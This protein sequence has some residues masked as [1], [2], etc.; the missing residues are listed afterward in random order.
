[1]SIFRI[2]RT[3]ISF[4]IL[5]LSM[6]VANIITCVPLLAQATNQTKEYNPTS[7]STDAHNLVY[8]S[9]GTTVIRQPPGNL[10]YVNV[11]SPSFRNFLPKTPNPKE[12]EG[13]PD[14]PIQGAAFTFS[15]IS[16]VSDHSSS[17]MKYLR[18]IV[19][20]I[21]GTSNVYTNASIY[22]TLCKHYGLI[23]ESLP[24]LT[25]CRKP[26][27]CDQD[28]A[29]KSIDYF[30]PFGEAVYLMCLTPPS[31]AIKPLS[32]HAS[33]SLLPNV[34]VYLSFK[35]DYLPL[36]SYIQADV[37]LRKAILSSIVRQQ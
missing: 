4:L 5:V 8:L 7:C 35:T 36:I 26:F 20:V 23:D 32:C 27:A 12:P 10:T 9:V 16:F 28:I 11:G 17:D 25:G 14:H 37:E 2:S 1:M 13:C 21:N 6:I 19:V 15:H 34:E 31:C 3:L 30:T 29:Y 22:R 24:G 18:N 33:Y